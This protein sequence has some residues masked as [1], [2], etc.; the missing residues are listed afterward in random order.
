MV[1]ATEDCEAGSAG[2]EVG[3]IV[4]LVVAATEG[5]EAE[6]GAA[7]ANMVLDA[8]AGCEVAIGGG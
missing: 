8:T 3:T 2:F 5:C 4:I 1:A 6:S 7:T